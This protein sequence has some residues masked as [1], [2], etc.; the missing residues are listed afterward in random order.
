MEFT[1]TVT[2]LIYP[3]KEG[4][5]NPNFCFDSFEETTN[6]MNTCFNN[7]YEVIVSRIDIEEG[8]ND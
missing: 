7:D 3:E 8:E 2:L 5:P 4:I 6:F 1:Y